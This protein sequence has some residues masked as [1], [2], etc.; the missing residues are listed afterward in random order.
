MLRNSGHG[1]DRSAARERERER[2]RER[3]EEKRTRTLLRS[4]F[5]PLKGTQIINPV[6]CLHGCVSSCRWIS[7]VS[8][9]WQICPVQPGFLI[10]QF[11][12]CKWTWPSSS[13]I[14]K[15]KWAKFG[16]S[17]DRR[18]GKKIKIESCFVLATSFRNVLSKYGDFRPLFPQNKA[19]VVHF[20][21]FFKFLLGRPVVSC[22]GSQFSFLKNK[23]WISYMFLIF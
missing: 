1:S 23:L 18:V 8:I 13:S 16:Y 10:S 17:S 3:R 7:T 11:L 15:R 9:Y 5:G 4:G 6:V 19:T 14:H 12:W 22:P 2:E 20:I 21:L